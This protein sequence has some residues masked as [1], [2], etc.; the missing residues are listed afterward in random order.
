MAGIADI[1]DAAT[2]LT[3]G[4]ASG[5]TKSAALGLEAEGLNIRRDRTEAF[6]RRTDIQSGSLDQRALAFEEGRAKRKAEF[7]AVEREN[8]KEATFNT[9]QEIA[10]GV[11]QGMANPAFVSGMERL[12][13]RFYTPN[14]EGKFSVTDQEDFREKVYSN[15]PKKQV[16]GLV[17]E[18]I[19]VNS[20]SIN[21]F[22][23]KKDVLEFD[24]NKLYEKNPIL[25]NPETTD[26]KVMELKSDID[27]LVEGSNFFSAQNAGMKKFADRQMAERNEV[28]QE[29]ISTLEGFKGARVGTVEAPTF[30]P[31]IRTQLK[32]MSEDLATIDR[33]VEDA[34]EKRLLQQA[35]LREGMSLV[36]A[37]DQ[38]KVIKF[39][40]PFAPNAFAEFLSQ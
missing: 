39:L 38:S 24:L 11:T 29:N 27:A 2:G 30:T 36:S 25:R 15:D 6:D 23:N 5:L 40:R 35:I 4:A 22:D 33:E 28:F 37:E 18:L 14:E 19:K 13:N 10:D 26:P 1:I 8:A 17:D 16:P 34:Q 32:G 3:S 9:T 31:E 21:Q 12:L 20:S 7:E